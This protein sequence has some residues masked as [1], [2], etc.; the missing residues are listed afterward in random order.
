MSQRSAWIAAAIATAEVSEPPRPSVVMR[1]V[2]LCM[3]WKP[4]ITATSLRSLKRLISSSPLMSR[5]RAAPWAL[6]VRIGNCQPCQERALMPI[7][8]ST[9]ASR[10]AVT[11]SPEATTASYSRA[12]CSGAASRHQLTSWL[13]VPAMAETTTATSW[14]ASTSRLTWRATLRMRSISATEVPP[15]FITR[16]AMAG[17]RASPAGLGARDPLYGK[18]TRENAGIHTGGAGGPQPRLGRGRWQAP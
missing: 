18:P 6:E 10:P 1:P 5:M 11:C 9:I 17:L 4:A 16:R 13:V 2:S 14:P 15:N 7:P 12:S 8:S 3:P